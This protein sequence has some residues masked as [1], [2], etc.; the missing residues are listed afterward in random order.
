MT[1]VV[2]IAAALLA[3]AAGVQDDGWVI[4][5]LDIR[6]DIR[7]D[8]R[9]LVHESIDVDFDGLSRHGIYRDIQKLFAYDA[10][11]LR[12]YLIDLTSVT[13]GAG[14]PLRVK[15][16]T[17]DAL[18]RFQIG[19]PDRTVSGK[20]T[21]RLEYTIAGAL[22]GF[23]D[24]DELYWNASGIWPVPIRAAQ[25]VVRAPDG[26][27]N[28]T[29]CLQGPLGPEAAEGGDTPACRSEIRNGEARYTSLVPI[30]PGDQM[31]VVTG[32]RKG[33][34]AEPSPRLIARR[35]TGPGELFE[36][37]TANLALTGGALV[38]MVALVGRLWWGIGRDRRYIALVRSSAD[39]A[40]ERVPL[41]GA[42]PIGVQF[43]PPDRLRPAQIGL[44]IDERADTLDVTATIID[45][46]VRGY[47][48][49][50]EIPKEGWFGKTDW[51]L[52]RLK[53]ADA[54]LLDY[55]RVVMTGL[56]NGDRERRVSDLKDKF[57]THLAKA[58]KALY[59]D[60]VA[61]GWFP[62]N[63]NTVRTVSVVMGL[64]AVMVGVG[65]TVLLAVWFGAGL[66][67]LP[68]IAGGILL[69][70][71][72][73]AMP[74]R[75]AAGRELMHRALGFA[76]YVQTGETRQQ[77]FAERAQIFTAYLPY[78]I[79]FKCVDRWA[80][81]FR[82]IDTQAATA[83]FYTGATAFD[84]TRFTSSMSS[85]SS[86]LSSSLAST[87]GGSGSSGFGGGGSSGGGG[88]GGGGG[89]W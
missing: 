51:R 14:Q 24:H 45:L 4:E 23:S 68:V 76:K 36:L 39:A 8:G 13:T 65:L 64:L 79:V 7:P 1:R 71:L 2:V 21:Y 73:R 25:V 18:I 33:A 69:M 47:L 19:D 61:R 35:R 72:S 60:A 38:L 29:R 34:V 6:Y 26:A 55:E 17:E 46:A 80:W 49:I 87:P 12:E 82:D 32:L 78:A 30:T 88:G 58:R 28:R 15:T 44:L 48:T 66:I 9:V 86:S 27:I 70:L 85:F 37:T 11:R 77:E 84:A 81:A 53:D 50:A 52:T 59:A 74:R 5:R 56:F 31:T 20:Q 43:E 67:G 40:D 10:A 62:R 41:F 54:D 3:F 83:G 63:P 22:N 89:S 16:I 57:Y 75:T 42:R